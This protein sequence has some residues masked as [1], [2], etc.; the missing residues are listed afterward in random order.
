MT[1]LRF[2][3]TD[4]YHLNSELADVVN[5]ATV[6]NKPLLLTGEAGTGKTQL[7]HEIARFLGLGIE[8]ARC[9]STFRGEEMCYEHDAILRLYDARFSS[10]DTGRDVSR[11]YD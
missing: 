2:T 3:G 5:M 9:K 8:I 6:M 7:A 4:R 11:F 1:E 10:V